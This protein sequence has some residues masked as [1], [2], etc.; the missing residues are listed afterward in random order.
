MTITELED[1]IRQ[2]EKK[3]ES[4]PDIIEARQQLAFLIREQEEDC[5]N[6]KHGK[7][8]PQRRGGVKCDE[9]TY[10]FCY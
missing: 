7:L 1:Y 10:W 5:P 2:E 6:C 4:R 8:I 9:C 3:F